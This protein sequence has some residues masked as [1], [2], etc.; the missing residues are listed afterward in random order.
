MNLPSFNSYNVILIMVDHVIKMVHL[1]LWTKTIT[2]EKK[3]KQFFDHVFWYHNFPKYI[4]FNH[5]P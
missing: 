3:I 2:W 5:G 1:I 4:I